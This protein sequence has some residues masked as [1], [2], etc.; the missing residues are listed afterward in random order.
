M[1]SIWATEA[2]SQR[3][4]FEFWHEGKVV[5]EEGDTLK[6]MIKYDISTDIIQLDQKGHL[7]S[8]TARKIIYYEIFDATS[9]RYRQFYSIPYSVTGGYKTPIFFELLSEGK[10]T[11]LAREAL[12]YKTSST[13]LYGYGSISRQ[14]LV[15]KFFVLTDKGNVEE[16]SGKRNDLLALM[17]KRDDEIKKYIKA[18]RLDIDYKYDVARVFAYYNSLFK[19]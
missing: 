15:D 9:S 13:G 10:L 19:N 16:F 7:Q 2:F 4:P 8:F 17:A 11:L 12:E 5:L 14:V 1:I 18:N 3:W 6:G